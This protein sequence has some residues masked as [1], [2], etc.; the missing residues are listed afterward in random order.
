MDPSKLPLL[1][2]IIEDGGGNVNRG[3]GGDLFGEGANVNG[4]GMCGDAGNNDQGGPEVP[5]LETAL[6]SHLK[7]K[8]LERDPDAKDGQDGAAGGTRLK[9]APWRK[10][11]FEENFQMLVGFKAET[12]HASPPVKHPDLGPWVIELRRNKKGLEETG[13]W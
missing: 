1:L 3:N 7:R 8:V 9:Q 6:E 12:G 11:S 5:Y 10:R 13:M 4:G 2:G